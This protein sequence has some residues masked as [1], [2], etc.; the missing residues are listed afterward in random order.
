M[1]AEL[2][3]SEMP[4][5]IIYDTS[6]GAANF[7][8]E[9]KLLSDLENPDK[10]I[11]KFI[12]VAPYKGI[13]RKWLTHYQINDNANTDQAT[14]IVLAMGQGAYG[15]VVHSFEKQLPSFAAYIEFLHSIDSEAVYSRT[16]SEIVEEKLIPEKAVDLDKIQ[17]MSESLNTGEQ[18][19]C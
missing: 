17:A 4:D 10:G 2:D 11:N 5:H 3:K 16:M 12:S 15:V 9:T 1:N 13:E 7:G 14:K 6:L 8:D 19:V 18:F